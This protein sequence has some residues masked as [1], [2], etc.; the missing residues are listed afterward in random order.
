[1][2][3]ACLGVILLSVLLAGI[4][5]VLL[6]PTLLGATAGSDAGLLGSLLSGVAAIPTLLGYFLAFALYT[7]WMTNYRFSNAHLG[8]HRFE[9]DYRFGSYAW[10]VFGNTLGML[11][12]LGLFY[13]WARVRS[14]RYAAAHTR[15]I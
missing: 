1:T 6:V 14:A 2:F 5:V 3:A 15:V 12:T 13:P 10:L 7:A 11:L 8:T 4:V 9:A